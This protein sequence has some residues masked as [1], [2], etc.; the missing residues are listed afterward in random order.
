MLL[1]N[2]NKKIS[3]LFLILSSALYV[4]LEYFLPRTSFYTLTTLWC[5]LFGMC[6][7]LYKYSSLNLKTLFIAG[8]IFRLLLLA[9]IPPLS[10]DFN[11]FIWDGRILF[12]GLNPYSSTPKQ[13]IESNN[14]IIHNA[15]Q[16]F[17]AMGLLNASNYSNYPPVSQIGY[18]IAAIF[19]SKSILISII[20]MRIQLII[21]DIGIYYFGKKI[22]TIL[23]LPQKNILLYFLNPF[24][25]LELTG[26]LHYEPVMV[27][28]LVSSLYFLIVNNWKISAV[29]LGISINVKLLP[30]LFIPIFIGYFFRERI[31]KQSLIFSF[32]SLIKKRKNI[33]IYLIYVSIALGVNILLFLPFINDAFIS[34]YTSS[35]GL[36][37]KSFEF[38]ASIYYIIRWIGFQ[39][40]GWNII[41]TTGKVLPVFVILFIGYLSIFR[42][43][44]K[45]LNLFT[46]LLFSISIHLMLTTTVHPWYLSIP[47]ALSIFTNYKYIFIWTLSIVLSYNAYSNPIFKE[48]LGFVFLEYT[49]V[50]LALVYDFYR[51]KRRIQKIRLFHK[52][53]Y[54]KSKI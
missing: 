15:Q 28:F 20:V 8:I 4:Y 26:N 19:G 34:N 39:T 24:I 32:S 46:S 17:K 50:A 31:I 45:S 5:I 13:W 12:K 41:G 21:S 29:L 52:D 7:C 9:A 14:F 10:Q 30:L 38:N 27:F 22:L 49:L 1:D 6:Y 47:L 36:W 23:K 2:E 54:R 51:Q 37:F 35:I 40:V 3:Y 42:N 53:T 11:R 48:N 43:N 25:I 44:H 16:L 18:L 33:I